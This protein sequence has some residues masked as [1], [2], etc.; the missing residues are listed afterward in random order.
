MKYISSYKVF[1]N[2]EEFY[3]EISE[4]EF[5]ETYELVDFERRYY[6]MFDYV[7]F[8]K[9]YEKTNGKSVYEFLIGFNIKH[10]SFVFTKDNH[11]KIT[12]LVNIYQTED[13]YF[14]VRVRKYDWYLNT[15]NQCAFDY[16][17]CDQIDGLKKFLDD[18][19]EE[20]SEKRI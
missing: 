1:E 13:E 18:F 19:T 5:C 14:D 11:E 20:Y 3:K 9:S 6:H 16:Y 4:D 17:R 2:K 10:P 15:A 12:V 8:N 7:P